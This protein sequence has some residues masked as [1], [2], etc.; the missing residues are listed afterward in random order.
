[1]IISL[2]IIAYLL[3]TFLIGYRRGFFLELMSILSTIF[4][5]VIAKLF[6]LKLTSKLIAKL[7][8]DVPKNV[9]LQVFDSGSFK[10]ISNSFFS[11]FVFMALFFA[12]LVI[13]H[14]LMIALKRFRKVLSFGR[15]GKI[16]AGLIAL[17]LSYFSIQLILT[18]LAIFPLKVLQDNLATSSVARWIVLESPISSNFLSHLFIDTIASLPKAQGLLEL[19]TRLMTQLFY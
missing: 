5:L 10:N 16:I 7:S 15:L 4:S 18:T 9:K 14:L 12:T 1:M 6:Y 19:G 3:L 11:A 8:L 17:A 2:V 13:F